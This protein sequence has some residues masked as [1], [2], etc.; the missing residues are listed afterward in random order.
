M[1]DY[2]DGTV[3][4]LGLQ[5]Q[6]PVTAHIRYPEEA[7]LALVNNQINGPFGVILWA[8]IGDEVSPFLQTH[9]KNTPDEISQLLV[10]WQRA[11][12]Y[13][14]ALP[15]WNS[16]ST[17][18]PIA[19]G[20]AKDYLDHISQSGLFAQLAAQFGAYEFGYVATDDLVGVIPLIDCEY[21]EQLRAE[22]IETDELSVAKFSIP[23]VMNA[24][25]RAGVEAPGRAANFVSDIKTMT[26]SGV[27]LQEA[28]G[29]GVEVKY[30]VSNAATFVLA[31]RVGDRLFLRS[32]I[33]RAYLLASLGL[34]TIPCIVVNES[35][36]PLLSGGYPAF[37]ATA[38]TL[39]R[40]PLFK[41]YFDESLSLTARLQR[42]TKVI[43]ITAEEFLVPVD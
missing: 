3:D 5:T 22:L 26:I 34:K 6:W 43:R 12:N 20:P 31:S 32:G 17:I 16:R 36:I 7:F 29:V 41:D 14:N 38:L 35:Q 18:E 8:F 2:A 10:E 23:E 37:S 21:V 42:M 24:S 25:I 13:R 19:S 39:P 28:P 1:Q 40:P 15:A 30:L 11:V 27:R 9:T 4:A 33:H